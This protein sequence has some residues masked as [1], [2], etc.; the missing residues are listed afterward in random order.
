MVVEETFEVMVMED[1]GIGLRGAEI[2]TKCEKRQISTF[3]AWS[4][5]DMDRQHR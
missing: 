1:M 3:A 2:F 5:V 4:S